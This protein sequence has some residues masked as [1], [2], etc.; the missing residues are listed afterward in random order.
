MLLDNGAY[1]I[2]AA[3]RAAHAIHARGA[4]AVK[5]AASDAGEQLV[6]HHLIA[7]KKVEEVQRNRKDNHAIQRADHVFLIHIFI[8][9]KKQRYVTYKRRRTHGQ[10]GHIIGEHAHAA[11]AAAEHFVRQVEGV[12]RYAHNRAGQRHHKVL[13]KLLFQCRTHTK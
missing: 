3:A 1:D 7:C 10:T 5:H 11:D 12:H 2:R 8:G 6:M 9:Q 4:N 13:I